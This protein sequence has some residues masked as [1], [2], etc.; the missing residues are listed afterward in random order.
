MCPGPNRELERE[1]EPEII[2]EDSHTDGP[3]VVVYDRETT[4][5]HFCGHTKP[6][7][8]L[9]RTPDSGHGTLSSFPSIAGKAPHV[10]LALHWLRDQIE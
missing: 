1:L 4:A 8:F 5:P 2:A 7:S 10:I 9:L 6:Y 3:Y